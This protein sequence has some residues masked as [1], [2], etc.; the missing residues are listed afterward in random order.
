MQLLNFLAQ[1]FISS[2][3]ITQPSTPKQQRLVSIILG[4]LILTT[5]V[6]VVSIAGFLLYQLRP[7]R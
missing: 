7:G 2:F 4:G 3:G 6:V 1:A 5:F